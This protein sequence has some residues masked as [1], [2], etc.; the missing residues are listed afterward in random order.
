MQYCFW[1]TSNSRGL[2]K[3]LKRTHTEDDK[4]NRLC[5]QCWSLFTSDTKV[6]RIR[7]C[8]LEDH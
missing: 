7:S 6:R 2:Q 4:A 8:P 3:H 1:T 5:T